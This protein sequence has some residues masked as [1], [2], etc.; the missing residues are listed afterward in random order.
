MASA[1][2]E[3]AVAN[4]QQACCLALELV[5]VLREI[6]KESQDFVG[7]KPATTEEITKIKS[8]N[9]RS[10]PGRFETIG[11]LLGAHTPRA[12]DALVRDAESQPRGLE[13]P[14]IVVSRAG[15]CIVASG[16]SYSCS[17]GFNRP[18]LTRA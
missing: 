11:S 1:S 12:F 7:K 5:E 17:N 15:L 8:R 16:K 4:L 14:F 10:L 18:R 13:Q 3:D 2:L 9:V 6:Q